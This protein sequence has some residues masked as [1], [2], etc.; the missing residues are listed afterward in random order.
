M[1]TSYSPSVVAMMREEDKD[2]KVGGKDEGAVI[3]WHSTLEGL[4]SLPTFATPFY[5]YYGRSYPFAGH[6]TL[7]S[8]SMAGEGIAI[9]RGP[10]GHLPPRGVGPAGV[11]CWACQP[12]FR[13]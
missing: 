10:M 6:T 5:A 12:W 2:H 8:R 4:P 9:E 3:L 7:I 13:F 1:L 11:V